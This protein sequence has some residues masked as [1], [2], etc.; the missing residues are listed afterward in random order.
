MLPKLTIMTKE[1]YLT[2]GKLEEI[3]KELDNL[4][5]VERPKKT[6][7]GIVQLSLL[8]HLR[9]KSRSHR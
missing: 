5:K 1:I 6:N 3:E 2:K 8:I 7:T 4:K 9:P